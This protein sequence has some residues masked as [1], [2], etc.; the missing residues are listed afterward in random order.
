MISELFASTCLMFNTV[1]DAAKYTPACISATNAAIIQSNVK[2][3][4]DNMENSFNRIVDR[5]AKKEI[6]EPVMWGL[7]AAYYVYQHK[8]NPG[9]S[10]NFAFKPYVDSMGLNVYNNTLGTTLIWYW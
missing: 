3:D 4:L 5:E 2:S 7:G 1:P 8:D 6:S 9:L 10:L